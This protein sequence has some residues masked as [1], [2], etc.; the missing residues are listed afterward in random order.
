MSADAGR[1][2]PLGQE[3]ALEGDPGTVRSQSRASTRRGHQVTT[4]RRVAER[5]N[6]PTRRSLWASR[7]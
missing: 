3:A 5:W 7:R 1:G 4:N 2:Y 6:T